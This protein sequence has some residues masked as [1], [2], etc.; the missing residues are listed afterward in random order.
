VDYIAAAVTLTAMFLVGRHLWWG[1]LVALLAEGL[2]FNYAR[3][4]RI[5]GLMM[6]CVV[7]AVLY[8]RNAILWRIE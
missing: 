3:K 4:R 5:R 8:L 7:Y 6:L 2:W 1:W